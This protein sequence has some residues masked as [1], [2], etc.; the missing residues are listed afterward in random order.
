MSSP[1]GLRLRADKIVFST[2]T[3]GARVAKTMSFTETE[4]ENGLRRLTGSAPRKTGTG[5]YDLSDA[6]EGAAV[7]CSFDPQP[8]AVLSPLIRL[9]RVSVV[10]DMTPLP[11]D[12][13][14]EFLTR[15]E[16]TFQRGGG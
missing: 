2:E 3:P 1:S 14:L 7:T 4:F 10:L 11:E 9:P 13:R 5:V 6:A 12:A 8:D 15:F 16:K